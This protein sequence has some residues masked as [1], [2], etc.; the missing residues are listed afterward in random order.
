MW[1]IISAPSEPDE[2][3]GGDSNDYSPPSRS[4]PASAAADGQHG[5]Q[6]SSSSN[7]VEDDATLLDFSIS[8]ASQLPIVGESPVQT[9]PPQQ[10]EHSPLTMYFNVYEQD[11]EAGYLIRALATAT[12]VPTAL[13]NATAAPPE[14]VL[15]QPLA[16][17]E[18][19]VHLP[20]P[21]PDESNCEKWRLQS[22]IK[23]C[24]NS[25]N[26]DAVRIWWRN[27]WNTTDTKKLAHHNG[28]PQLDGKVLF[29]LM[30]IIQGNLRRDIEQLNRKRHRDNLLT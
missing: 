5:N 20:K 2:P 3:N 18:P 21:T 15:A 26:P 24:A 22:E 8:S 12:A 14:D 23:L 25:N 7:N 13:A 27:I 10:T 30:K 19:S 17:Y 16:K 1:S 6:R 9:K 29:E 11:A 4:A 28:Q